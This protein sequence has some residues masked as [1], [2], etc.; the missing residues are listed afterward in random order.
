MGRSLKDNASSSSSI[1]TPPCSSWFALLSEIESSNVGLVVFVEF[2][3]IFSK[4]NDKGGVPRFIGKSIKSVYEFD[5][6]EN[7][8]R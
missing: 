3:A 5:E 8:A 2:F 6:R 1:S 4:N 7:L